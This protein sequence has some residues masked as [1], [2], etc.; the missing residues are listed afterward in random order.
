MFLRL[1]STTR[2][3]LLALSFLF[4]PTITSYAQERTVE[5]GYRGARYSFQVYKPVTIHQ[6]NVLPANV[7]AKLTAYLK[8]RLGTQFYHRLKF[9]EGEAI[10]LEELYR[11]EPTWKAEKVGSYDLVFHF[12][13]EP[14][15]LK[16]FYSKLLLDA[17][18]VVMEEINLPQIAGAPLKAKLIS[19]KQALKIATQD[20]FVGQHL[21]PDFDYYANTDSFAWVIEDSEAITKP[22]ICPSEVGPQS[23]PEVGHA[24]Y[25]RV[26][27]EAHTG[28]IL[29]RECY[30]FGF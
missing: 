27:I 21:S 3:A 4:G 12:S 16:A 8:Q 11:T 25:R 30:S 20:G 23:L 28:R 15:G 10:N 9:D 14:N 18:G 5:A 6:L 19:V 22:G 2:I 24:L 7:V 17:N 1:P 29:K 13:D 26:F